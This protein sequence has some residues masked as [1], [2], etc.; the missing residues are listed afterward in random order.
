M[1]ISS[2]KLQEP[3]KS[4]KPVD[5]QYNKYI[6]LLMRCFGNDEKYECDPLFFI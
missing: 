5:K 4:T 1:R 2:S 3:L 6:K